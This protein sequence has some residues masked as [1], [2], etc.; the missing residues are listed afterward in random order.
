MTQH[1]NFLMYY[2]N[3]VCFTKPELPCS[4][5]FNIMYFSL[6]YYFHFTTQNIVFPHDDI[7]HAAQQCFIHIFPHLSTPYCCPIRVAPLSCTHE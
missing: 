3:S 7:S 2:L 5:S 6:I 1:I 4:V